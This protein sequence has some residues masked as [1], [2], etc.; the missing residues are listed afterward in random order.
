[1]HPSLPT[2]ARH[3]S[4]GSFGEVRRTLEELVDPAWSAAQ[5]PVRGASESRL[6]SILEN[7]SPAD[8]RL[9][10]NPLIDLEFVARFHLGGGELSALDVL[11]R[12]AT[13]F[14]PRGAS[15]HPLLHARIFNICRARA[16]GDGRGTGRRTWVRDMLREPDPTGRGF[17]P[18]LDPAFILKQARLKLCNIGSVGA[19]SVSRFYLGIGARKGF[20][21]HALFDPVFVFVHRTGRFPSPAELSDPGSFLISELGFYIEQAGRQGSASPS[22]SFDETFLRGHRAL[23][24]AIRTQRYANAFDAYV[25]HSDQVG[26]H[27][28]T[29][30]G[31]DAFPDVVRPKVWWKPDR[32]VPTH[33]R[34]IGDPTA[35]FLAAAR[36]RLAAQRLCPA[37]AHVDGDLPHSVKVGQRLA[38]VI[39]GY[40]LS[41]CAHFNQVELRVG[42]RTTTGSFQR[43]PRP[44]IG[45]AVGSIFPTSARMLCGFAIAWEGLISKAGDLRLAVRFRAGTGR[46][47]RTTRWFPAGTILVETPAVRINSGPPARVAIAMATYEP[48]PALFKAQLDSIRRQTMPHW[49]L[50]ISDDSETARGR[51]AIEAIVGDDAR[52]RVIAGSRLGF[53]GNFERALSHLDRRSPYFALSDQD[54]VWYPQ[55]LATLVG[56]IEK[57]GAALAY[58]GMRIT[59]ESGSILDESFFS[60]RQRHGDTTKELLL[61]NTVTGAA[62]LGRMT[63]MRDILP[64]PRYRSAFHDM[65]IALVASATGGVAFV[66]ETLQDYV[67]HDGN[68]LGQN[69]RTDRRT[70][71]SLARWGRELENAHS[72]G[73]R[74]SQLARQPSTGHLRLLGLLAAHWPEALQREFLSYALQARLERV[75]PSDPLAPRALARAARARTRDISRNQ[76][77]PFL[78][79]PRWLAAGAEL[80]ASV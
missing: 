70:A 55:K 34:R 10:I 64:I 76:A 68:V 40:A 72:L 26:G 16:G 45:A 69:G 31:V 57:S 54:D 22:L 49:Q 43:F 1:M 75:N 33:S 30:S 35:V 63:L 6:I 80:L 13:D 27:R 79:L 38:I 12:Y 29:R 52:V 14:L 44:D 21:P 5:L 39:H 7:S 77:R 60:W 15:P 56:A 53:V 18:F 48:D 32:F 50:V 24:R 73:I 4:S 41:P 47:V 23:A 42:R 8:I 71:A 3:R 25:A 51:Q 61:A 78:N 74:L 65:W 11:R 9:K 46:S 36:K 17:I 59:T 66:P 37:L 28:C 67:Q 62:C 2:K 19:S 58:G 20:L